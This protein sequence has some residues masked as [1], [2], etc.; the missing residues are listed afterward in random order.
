MM[1]RKKSVYVQYRCSFLFWNNFD[2]KLVEPMGVE[3]GDRR[4]DCVHVCI[5]IHTYI[6]TYTHIHAYI[7]TYIY[8]HAYIHMYMAVC[9]Y[10]YICMYT[11]TYMQKL[12][13]TVGT[14][15]IKFR[16]PMEPGRKLWPFCVVSLVRAVALRMDLE[17]GLWLLRTGW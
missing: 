4:A 2:L 12:W 10:T 8:M 13:R 11:Y 15:S 6:H 16:M 9:I 1:T 3:L 17:G 7:Y 14:M 5:D